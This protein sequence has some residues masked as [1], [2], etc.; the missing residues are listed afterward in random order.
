MEIVTVWNDSVTADRFLVDLLATCG[1]YGS[2]FLHNLKVET[3]PVEGAEMVAPAQ[4]LARQMIESAGG[5]ASHGRRAAPL[6]HGGRTKAK[7]GR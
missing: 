4:T 6:V 3:I 1:S 2:V 7:R 5:F